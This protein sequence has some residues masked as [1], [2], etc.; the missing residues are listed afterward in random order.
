MN[1]RL[2]ALPALLALTSAAANSPYIHKVYEFVPAP[3]QFVNELPE[4]EPGDTYSS[5]L[6]K[7]QEAL[8]GDRTPGAVSLGAFGGYV[9]FGFDHPVVNEPGSPD[10]KIY[11]NAIISDRDSRGG[12]SEPGVIWV[13]ADVNGNG[14]PDDPWY[15]LAGSE[16]SRSTRD[17][18][19]TYRR[20]DPSHKPTPHP[21]DR[22][23]TD[24]SYLPWEA[25]D[26]TTGFLSA[27]DYHQQ[28]YWPEWETASEITFT[29][30]RVPDNAM[31]LNG[32]GTYFL[33]FAYPWGYAD[34]LPNR[35]ETGFDIGNAID[36]GGNAVFLPAIDFVKVATGLHQQCL[37]LGE[38]STEV[39]GA[40]DLHPDAASVRSVSAM[41]SL[42]ARIDGN[43]LN[44]FNGRAEAVEAVVISLGGTVV[45]D[46]YLPCGASAH[47][48]PPMSAGVYVLAAP[49]AEPVKL[50]YLR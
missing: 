50:V 9:V 2:L 34:N 16:S 23:V 44:V 15:E 17:F 35:E 42:S 33:M 37:S 45:A 27:N 11:G 43:T 4:Y 21:G 49:G 22:H 47:V 14:L 30:T 1:Y 32:D 18:S 13:S 19:V 24:T 46:L 3:G 36:A 12:S 31:D 29:G 8:A 7:A 40:E 48:L 6:A 41:A 10:F 20:P 39:C 26:G 38:S 5:M 28:S 25:S